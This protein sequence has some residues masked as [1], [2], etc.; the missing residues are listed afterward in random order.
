MKQLFIITLLF[1]AAY[2]H[3]EM[4]NPPPRLSRFN[5]FVPEPNIDYN[6][7]APLLADGSNFPCKN[8]PRSRV[9]RTLTAGSVETV[10][11]SGSVFHGYIVIFF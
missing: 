7:V 11:M 8:Y 6:M 9:V 4:R 1:I 3:M 2:C 5:P 10:E